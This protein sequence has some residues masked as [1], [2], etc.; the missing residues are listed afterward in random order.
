[1]KVFVKYA[2]FA[3]F[4][5]LASELLKH[6]GINNHAI[7]LINDHPTHPQVDSSFLTGSRTDAFNYA[8]EFLIT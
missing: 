1:M 3:F 7:E 8:P 2:N 5:D 6:I 4:S